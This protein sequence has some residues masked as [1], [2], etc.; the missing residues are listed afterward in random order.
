[1]RTTPSILAAVL[2]V[3]FTLAGP[4]APTAAN[5]QPGEITLHAVASDGA[6]R[7]F[8]VSV[9][10]DA[11]PGE[12]LPVV[13]GFHGGGGN[14]LQFGESSGL[15]EACDERGV[16]LV[17]PEGSG[18]LGG[19][20][21]FMLQTWN[22]EACCAFAAKN[23]IDDV[24]FVADLLDELDAIWSVDAERVF[25]TGMSNGGMMSYRVGTELSDRIAAIAPVAACNF[26][27]DVPAVPVPV[28]AIHGALDDNVPY[29]GG[30][31]SGVS[32]T[33]MVGQLESLMPFFSANES[34]V[35][36]IPERSV[37]AA[38]LHVLPSPLGAPIHYWWL[39]DHG[40]AWPGGD[41]PALAPEEPTT[42]DIDANEEI[43]RFFLDVV[44]P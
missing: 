13:L 36:A 7:W 27:D 1:M 38:E 12:P 41:A 19:P 25:A 4:S 35:D 24:Q 15:I 37:G 23:D 28:M 21:L 26:S 34:L 6:L 11:A 2:C 18:A 32:G 33:E 16:L 5:A 14:A 3:P 10:A 17:L 29:Q 43:L 30:L 40:H 8:R 31:G 20:P 22:V 44:T 9:P 42:D 39:R